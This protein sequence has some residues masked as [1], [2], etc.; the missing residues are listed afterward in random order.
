LRK[1]FIFDLDDTIY[2]NKH[3]YSYPILEFEK[4]LLDTLGHQAP[5]VDVIRRLFSEIDRRRVHEINLATGLL[6]GYSMERFPDSMVECY[7]QIC[8]REEIPFDSKI[9][10]KLTE[11]GY[12]AFSEKLYEKKG[13]VKGTAEVLTYLKEQK[14]YLILL[15][16]GDKQV[17][18][19]KISA[20]KLEQW[21]DQIFIQPLKTVETFKGLAVRIHNATA[22][23]SVGNSLATD[24][25]PALEAGM[26]G[27]YIPYETWESQDEGRKALKILDP[28]Q[29]LVY[30]EIIEIKKNYKRLK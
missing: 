27:I 12:E 14:D 25:K 9:A 26:R 13:L 23:W 30:N 5:H 6:Y 18:G 10:G 1:V 17:Q 3:D 2:W 20:L 7:R 15:T 16:K 11:I 22:V 4:F 8:Q 19:R 29:V 24:I 21:F 28:N